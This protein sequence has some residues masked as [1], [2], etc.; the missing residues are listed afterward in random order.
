VSLYWII[1]L[2]I[3]CDL[4]KYHYIRVSPYYTRSVIWKRF[5]ILN[6]EE[7]LYHCVTIFASEALKN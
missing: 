1:V 4:A 5:L 3:D 6:T 7:R 2:G